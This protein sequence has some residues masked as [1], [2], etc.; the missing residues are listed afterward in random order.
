MLVLINNKE[1]HAFFI[2]LFFLNDRGRCFLSITSARW[3]QLRQGYSIIIC[4]DAALIL[5]LLVE[6][7]III[8]VRQGRDEVEDAKDATILLK[9]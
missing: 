6:V 1:C 4:L 3:S 8:I 7:V 5:E 9:A 2:S